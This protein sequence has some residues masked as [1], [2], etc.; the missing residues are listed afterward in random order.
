M[1]L[2][3][4]ALASV[5]L[6]CAGVA[7]AVDDY[8]LTPDSLPQKDVPK[9]K[10]EGPFEWKSKVFDGTTRQYW[11]YVPAQY[12]KAKSTC[13]MVFQDGHAYALPNE[14][15]KIPT[16]F[17]NLIHRQDMPVTLGVFI[18]PGAK[19]GE[20]AVDSKNWGKATRSFEYDSLGDKYAKFIVDEMLPEVGKSYNLTKDPE[21]R[22]ICGASSGGICAFTVAWERPDAFR[23]VISHIGSFTNLKGGHVYPKKILDAEKKPIRIYLQD[24]SG[25]NRSPKNLDRDWY[26]QNLAMAAALQEKGYDYK[27]AFGDGAH[28]HKHGAAILPDQLRWLWKDYRP[29]G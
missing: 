12:D 14:G 27:A 2:L 21:G 26:L 6:A 3:R 23:K 19:D 13:V 18:N 9:G 5:F 4:I 25:D 7:S 17:D 24:G 11:V 20:P 22:A 29:K 28:N 1:P 15:Y 16:V 10:L 8:A